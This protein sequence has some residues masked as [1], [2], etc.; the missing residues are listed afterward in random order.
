METS[1]QP[2]E[3]LIRAMIFRREAKTGI[4][5]IMTYLRARK[6]IKDPMFWP[7]RPVLSLIGVKNVIERL[8]S[9]LDTLEMFHNRKTSHLISIV[10][11]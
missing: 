9:D 10:R 6:T 8:R 7:P 3:R 1:S 11:L 5:E 2:T 4:G